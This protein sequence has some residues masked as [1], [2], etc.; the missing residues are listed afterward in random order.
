ML[1]S[2]LAKGAIKPDEFFLANSC[3]SILVKVFEELSQ[4]ELFQSVLVQKDMPETEI[5]NY[6]ANVSSS[7]SLTSMCLEDERRRQEDCSQDL[8]EDAEKH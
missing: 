6:F 8:E 7:D 2:K 5:F 1:L 3:S 4:I